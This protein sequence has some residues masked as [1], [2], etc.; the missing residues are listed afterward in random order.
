MSENHVFCNPSHFRCCSQSIN[1]RLML[2]IYPRGTNLPEAATKGCLLPE[3]YTAAPLG[4]FFRTIIDVGSWSMRGPPCWPCCWRDS[5]LSMSS[6]GLGCSTSQPSGACHGPHELRHCPRRR[7]WLQPAWVA[8]P[9]PA[10]SSYVVWPASREVQSCNAE[11]PVHRQDSSGGAN[12]RQQPLRDR[13]PNGKPSSRRH[14]LESWDNANQ[15]GAK[16][17]A[18]GDGAKAGRGAKLGRGA[19][20]GRGA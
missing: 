17:G 6:I 16:N 11:E 20:V 18:W 13:G 9:L 5:S 4:R 1:M 15:C 3:A 19:K 8:R 12:G 10:A 7:V 2:S 14:G